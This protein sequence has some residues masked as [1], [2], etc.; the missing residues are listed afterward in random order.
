MCQVVLARIAAACC[1]AL[2]S[3]LL[4]LLLR[5]LLDTSKR[6]INFH[7]STQLHSEANSE[8]ENEI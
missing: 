8:Q 3:L 2:A 6:S 5:L 1:C 4:L 7:L